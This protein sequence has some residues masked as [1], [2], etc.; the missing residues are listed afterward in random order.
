MAPKKDLNLKERPSVNKKEQDQ[1]PVVKRRGKHPNKPAPCGKRQAL[2]DDKNLVKLPW[3][4][5]G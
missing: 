4:V 2:L 5:S 3:S 1:R